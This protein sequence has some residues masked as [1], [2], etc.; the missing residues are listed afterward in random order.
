M[1]STKQINVENRPCYFFNVTQIILQF[2][3]QV[4][5]IDKLSF[6]S[7]DIVIYN[8]RYITMKSLDHVNTDSANP[9]N[10]FLIMFMVTFKKLMEINTWILLLQTKTE[11]I[12]KSFQ[13]ET[14]NGGQQIK[15]K[16][17][18]IKI[19][20]ESDNDFYIWVKY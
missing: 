9:L 18:F 11:S 15:F 8:I 7:T 1:R 5:C 16:K 14:I 4:L 17:D 2:L 13:I 19:R 3:I 10:L 6:K 20:F 12:R